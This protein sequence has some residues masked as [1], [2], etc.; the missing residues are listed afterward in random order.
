MSKFKKFILATS[1]V[2]IAVFSFLVPTFTNDRVEAQADVVGIS[3][4]FTGSNLYTFDAFFQNSTA[5]GWYNVSVKNS[6]YKNYGDDNVYSKTVLYWQRTA[7]DYDTTYI[8]C[9]NTTGRTYVAG[10]APLLPG[11][12][13]FLY[14]TN[15][16]S[17]ANSGSGFL[18]DVL[19]VGNFNG[20]VNRV[21]L[22]TKATFTNM[23]VS[24]TGYKCFYMNYYDSEDNYISYE[25]IMPSDNPWDTRTYY[26]TQDFSDTQI[27]NQGYNQGLLDNQSNIYNQGYNAGSS[28]GYGQGYAE[29]LEDGSDYSFFSLFGAVLDAPISALKGLLNFQIFGVNLLTLFTGLLTLA[30]ILLVIRLIRGGK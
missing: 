2:L 10:D 14:F 24:F 25:F 17:A 11:E 15:S 23:S 16:V 5:S 27:Y 18:A 8:Q 29:G 1:C 19:L 9:Y 22:G 3:Y 21:T 26:F 12:H 28:A 7:N 30:I 4:S 13:R 6:F 20:N